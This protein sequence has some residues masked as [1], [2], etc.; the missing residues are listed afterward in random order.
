VI[1]QLS[2]PEHHISPAGIAV[3][4]R[5]GTSELIR[6][7]LRGIK[8][9]ARNAAYAAWVMDRSGRATMLG[10]INFAPDQQPHQLIA[11]GDLPA[12]APHQRRLL[13]TLERSAHPAR[14]GEIILQ[15]TPASDTR[16]HLTA[17][18]R[19]SVVLRPTSSARSLSAAFACV[20]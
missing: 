14:P 7:A 4:T 12:S 19:L 20:T 11:E 16:A 2:A 6:L 15:A 3:I 13:I 18:Q 9:P 8:R 5:S 1:A 10:F 17:A